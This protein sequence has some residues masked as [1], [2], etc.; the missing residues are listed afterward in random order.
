M[1]NKTSAKHK[2]ELQK[3]YSS[4]KSIRELSD[5]NFKLLTPIGGKR[6]G[7]YLN[8]AR[9]YNYSGLFATLKSMLNVSIL[10][11]EGQEDQTL[12]IKDKESDI[13]NVLEFAKNLIPLEEGHFLDEMRELMI[14]EEKTS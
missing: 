8:H 13:I 1:K 10:A 2:K 6:G 4:L 5:E 7:Y 11:L 14:R 12:D 3:A 9:V